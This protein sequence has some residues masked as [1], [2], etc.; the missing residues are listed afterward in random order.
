MGFMKVKGRIDT[1]DF[2]N[3]KNVQVEYNSLGK[4]LI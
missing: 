2:V 1:D 4:N 3:S